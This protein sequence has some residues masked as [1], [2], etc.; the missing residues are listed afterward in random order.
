MTCHRPNSQCPPCVTWWDSAGSFMGAQSS[1]N[2]TVIQQITPIYC[3]PTMCK[4]LRGNS[5]HVN[6]KLGRL[7]WYLPASLEQMWFKASRICWI[8]APGLLTQ[9]ICLFFAWAESKGLGQIGSG[10][11]SLS[12]PRF[13]KAKKT[14]CLSIEAQIWHGAH[15]KERNKFLKTKKHPTI[16]SSQTTTQPIFSSTVNTL[17]QK[18]LLLNPFSYP[19]CSHQ[20]PAIP[21]PVQSSQGISNCSVFPCTWPLSCP[22]DTDHPVLGN[23]G[24]SHSLPLFPHH[25][26]AAFPFQVYLGLFHPPPKSWAWYEECSQ[27]TVITMYGAR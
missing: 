9:L 15:F 8:K 11:L 5:W 16:P 4:A 7:W 27:Q 18:F 1:L 19:P 17:E 20:P 12:C 26:L 14:C 10:W 21:L 22:W 25:H 2:I 13:W 3:V 6:W 23:I 24:P